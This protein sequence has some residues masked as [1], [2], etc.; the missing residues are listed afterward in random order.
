M[1]TVTYVCT[2]CLKRG[3]AVGIEVCIL[4]HSRTISSV[5]RA[6]AIVARS[7]VRVQYILRH[8]LRV[9]DR[10]LA[11]VFMSGGGTISIVG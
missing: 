1:G 5:G 8:R 2:R 4:G 10:L 11:G 7:L 3:V 9:F 6:A